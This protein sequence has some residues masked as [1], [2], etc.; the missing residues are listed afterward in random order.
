[1]RFKPSDKQGKPSDDPGFDDRR[2]GFG[3]QRR[4]RPQGR[5]RAAIPQLVFEGGAI[6]V[7]TLRVVVEVER[8]AESDGVGLQG[9]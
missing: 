7:I 2:D 8:V 5:V 9:G 3:Q 1:V 6:V 4:N